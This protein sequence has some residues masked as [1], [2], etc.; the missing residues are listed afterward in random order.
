MYR[1]VLVAIGGSPWS[2]AALSYAIALAA[3]TGADLTILTVLASPVAYTMP[4]VMSSSE[5]LMESIERQGHELIGQASARAEA[6]EVPYSAVAKWGSVPETILQTAQEGQCDLIILGSR[7]ITGWKRLMVGRTLNAVTARCEQPLLVVKHPPAVEL[8]QPT[9]RRLL[10][11]TGG[12]PWSDMAVEHA[13]DLAQKNGL[14]VCILCVDVNRAASRGAVDDNSAAKG[15][16]ANAEARAAAAG[17]TY[18]A[19]LAYGDVTEAV[20]ETAS[21]RQCDAIVMGSRGMTGLKR[22]MIGSISN[23]VAAKSL[24]PVMIVKRFLVA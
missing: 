10:V 16:L 9:W 22:L 24:L 12:S 11:A 15:I 18:E 4:D 13:L 20:L 6:A 3:A 23:A 5:L 17:V 7:V 21:S 14:E 19:H 2:D 1:K 8:G